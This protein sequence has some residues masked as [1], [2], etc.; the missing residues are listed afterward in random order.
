MNFAVKQALSRHPRGEETQRDRRSKEDLPRRSRDW[1]D[2]TPER[3]RER[4]REER[5][6]E[7]ERGRER[8]RKR[9]LITVRQRE[10][11]G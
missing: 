4:E 10:R 3:R 5:E 7:R 9:G 11:K 6:R 8:E 1:S 2:N